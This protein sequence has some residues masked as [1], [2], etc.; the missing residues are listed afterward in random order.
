MKVYA[1]TSV[2]GGPFDKIKMYNA[3]NQIYGYK[4][5]FINSP[6]EVIYY[7]E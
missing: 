7:E 1:D 6:S 5:I 4:E 2:F 3:V